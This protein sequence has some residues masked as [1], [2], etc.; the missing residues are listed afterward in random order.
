MLEGARNYISSSLG[1][2]ASSGTVSSTGVGGYQE[3]YDFV[4]SQAENLSL[5]EDASVDLVTTGTPQSQT[6][7]AS[8]QAFYRISSIITLVQLAETLARTSACCSQQRHCCILGMQPSLTRDS[9]RD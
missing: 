9:D 7:F 1:D 5:L 3:Q 4:Q 2:P 6:V 8:N